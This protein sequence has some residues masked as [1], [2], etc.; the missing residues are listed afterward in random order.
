MIEVRN[1]TKKYG[2]KLAV[3][4]ISFKVEKGEILGFLGPN[5]AGKSTTMNMLTGYISSTSGE[6]LIDGTDILEEPKKAKANIGYLP[7][8]PPIYVDMTVDAYLNFMFD[9]KKCKLPRK[10][11]LK[12][13]C[14]LCKIQD[15]RNRI[16]KNLSK[17][18]RQRV[19][20]AQALINNPPVLILDEPTVG[21][22]PNQIIEIRSLIKK[23]GKRH[24]VI[25][26]SHILPEIQAVCDRII[27]INKGQVAADG[28]ADEI[29][30][31]ITNEHKMTLR[32][33]GPTH[34]ADDKR[35]I[36]VAIK[37]ISGV[38]YVRADMERERG[39]YDYDIETDGKT[40]IRRDLNKLCAEKGWNILMLQ[41]SDLT[42]EDIFLKITMDEGLS[43]QQSN[44]SQ[45]KPKVE[46][47]VAPS[48]KLR[49]VQETD[50]DS[51]ENNGG[52]E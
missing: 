52:E 38:K 27:I 12:E 31:N 5:G 10:A 46:I 30:K 19:G 25:L 11:H 36:T 28:T 8:I 35:E 42:L 43:K 48:G 45:S 40:D 20:L 4:N 15:V 50:D 13:V 1:L 51:E 17:G 32:I 34:T 49:A 47:K 29:A 18:Y 44:E 24:T 33:E 41:L 7:E 3:N 37:T 16:I 2:D 39:V 21:L 6:V 22:D 9:L 14:G 23:L 26:S